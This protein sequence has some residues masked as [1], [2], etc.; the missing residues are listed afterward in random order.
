MPL[1]IVLKKQMQC[2]YDTVEFT[3]LVSDYH[4]PIKVPSLFDAFGS[5]HFADFSEHM[6]CAVWRAPA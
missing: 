3:P 6:A 5:P 1:F 2:S 4:K